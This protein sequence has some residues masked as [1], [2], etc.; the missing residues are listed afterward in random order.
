MP[1]SIAVC[2]LSFLIY[3][4]TLSMFSNIHLEL[5]VPTTKVPM[6]PLFQEGITLEITHMLASPA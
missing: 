5:N 4:H 1:T 6:L 3:E 2:H